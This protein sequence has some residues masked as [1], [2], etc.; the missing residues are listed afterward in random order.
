MYFLLTYR[1]WKGTSIFD[2]HQEYFEFQIE[3]FDLKYVIHI[4]FRLAPKVNGKN[5]ANIRLDED[6]L[7][8]S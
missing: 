7:K 5:P 8:T 6:V 1:N 2:L 4:E 3:W